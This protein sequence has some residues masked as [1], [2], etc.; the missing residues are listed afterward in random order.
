MDHLSLADAATGSISSD[1]YEEE[2]RYISPGLQEV[3]QLS[4]LVIKEGHGC[5]L[6]DVDGGSY[7]DLMAGIAVCSLGHS[8]ER[9]MAALKAQLDKVTVGS[10]T[11]EPRMKL[12][13]LIASINPSDLTGRR[14]TAAAQRPWRRLSGWPSHTRRASKSLA[15][16][17][18][19]TGKQG[20]F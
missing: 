4:R 14:F 9:Y 20:A 10:F 7:L 6:V 12:L 3:S 13:R 1:I 18:G 8:H 19:F 11:T 15:S 5:R 16:G 2:R 17:A